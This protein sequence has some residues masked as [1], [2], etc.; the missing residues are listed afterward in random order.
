[1]PDPMILRGGMIVDGTGRHEPEIADLLVRDGRIAAIGRLE[2]I[3]GAEQLDVSGLVVAPGFIDLHSHSDFTLLVDPRA[4]SQ[5]RQGVTT[6][7]VGNCGYGCCPI[8]D[9]ALAREA[10]YGFTPE[11]PL[12]WR[13]AA[14]YL[15]ALRAA[16]PAVNVM[17][18][19][20]NGQLRLAVLGIADRAA[21]P[22]EVA[23]MAALLEG[24]LDQGAAGYST[25][26]EYA[27]ESGASEAEVTALCRVAAARDG[28]YATHTRNRDE[29][30]LEA[31]GE[32][33]RT[34]ARTGARLQVSHITPR[35]GL[36]MAEQAIA[37]VD[38]ARQEGLDVAFDMHTR[39]FG[40]TY[41]KTL[42][43]LSVLAGGTDA[44][45]RRLRDPAER[46]R[47]RGHRSLIAAVG[48][49]SKVVLMD[50]PSFPELEGEDFAALARRWGKPPLDCALDV[51]LADC[52]QI[53]RPMVRL[54][55]Y[56]EEELMLTYRHPLCAIGSDATALAPDGPLAGSVFHGAYSW[57]AWFFR[58]AV[59][60]TGLL[61]LREAIHRLTGLPAERMRLSGRGRLAVGARADIAV[62]DPARFGE[63]AT[64]AEPNRVAEGMVHVLVNG[65][66]ALRDGAATGHRAGEVLQAG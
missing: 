38:R 54:R 63:R 62:L 17:T 25:G 16:G 50:S 53:H 7:I 5:I 59:R 31:I 3:D 30:A 66:P 13:D 41:L 40:T 36:A 34:A 56:T 14:G 8:G 47:I 58:R 37:M 20:P 10:I 26:L 60:E 64:V 9:P 57:A 55:T 11:H 23:A 44:V 33:L 2:P 18:L 35:R 49:W 27:T 29:G 52:D 61:S 32:A 65:V 1:M 4:V 45:V 12:T 22:E 6:E 39:L 21:R 42:L 46:D 51:L 48:D 43:P 15:A 24:A 19:V 28:L